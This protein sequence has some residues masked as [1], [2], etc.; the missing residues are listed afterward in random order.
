MKFTALILSLSIAMSDAKT[1]RHLNTIKGDESD[2]SM[3]YMLS[4]ERGGSSKSKSATGAPTGAPTSAPTP[5]VCGLC[6]VLC[7]FHICVETMA[8]SPTSLLYH[9]TTN[10]LVNVDLLLQKILPSKKILS[11]IVFNLP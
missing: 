9:T 2:A 3:S 1:R 10:S 7:V 6:I 8:I 4:P 5:E 11:V